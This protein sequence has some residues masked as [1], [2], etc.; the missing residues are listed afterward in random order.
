MNS[1]VRERWYTYAWGNNPK[2]AELRGRKCRILHSMKKGSCMVEFE[3]NQREVISRRAL[4][5][6]EP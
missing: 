5:R 6:L 2:R 4:R 1:T 3:N